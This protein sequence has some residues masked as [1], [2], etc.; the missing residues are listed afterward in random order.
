MLIVGSGGREH[1]LAWKVAQSSRLGKLCIAPAIRA[2]GQL[3][4]NVAIAVNDLH[5]LVRFCLAEEDRP[6]GDRPGSSPGSRAG[7]CAAAGRDPVFGPSAAAAQIEASKVF[8]KSI[9]CSAHGIPT[10]RY[11]A[12]HRL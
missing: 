3:G 11:A 8:C 12:F 7:G 2:R 9:S 10:A 4:E 6:G 1:A 5:G